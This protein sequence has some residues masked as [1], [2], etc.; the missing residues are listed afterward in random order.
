MSAVPTQL[1]LFA[2]VAAAY[3]DAAG[4]RLDNEG[5]YSAAGDRAGVPEAE[6]R[7]RRPVGTSA[8]PRNLFHRAVRWH[9]QTLKHMGVL[10]RVPGERGVWELADRTGSGLHRAL[11]GVRLVAFSTALGVAIWGDCI[12]TF[13]RLDTPITLCITSPPYCLSVPRSYGNPKEADYT[14]FIVASL[15]PIVQR[16]VP[17]G[18]IC[19][20]LGQDIFLPNSPA[21]SMINE[22]VLLALHDRLGLKLLD[23]LV[24][25][26]GSKPPGPTHWASVKRV[27][28]NATY[29]FIY[30]L[31][32]SPELVHADNRRVLQPHTEKHRLLIDAGGERRDAV[33][34]DGAY[35][36]RPGSFSN[37][38]AGKIPR[39]VLQYG[40][41]CADTLRYR[42]DAAA[43]RLPAHGATMPLSVPDFLIR[44]LSEPGDLIADPWGG[45]VKTGIAAERLGR[46]WM[47]TEHMLDFL[48]PAAERFRDFDG[49][50]MPDDVEVWP[51][52]A[53]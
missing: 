13:E 14:D 53:A 42:R 41:R 9:Q 40:G 34:G 52:K 10:R 50:S 26:N 1:Q 18:S 8:Q 35:H 27:Q 30:W 11:P 2:A 22:R 48:R 15:K 36:V 49:F 43:L 39:N 31:S 3:A 6:R 19:L 23:R 28:L 7:G 20:N 5:L 47:V 24:W 45:T 51:R 37:P 29:E 12:D 16:L 38:T 17:G 32:P 25:H 46:R 4:G 44:F 21:R 33:Y